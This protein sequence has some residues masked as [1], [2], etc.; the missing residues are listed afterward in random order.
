MIKTVKEYLFNDDMFEQGSS[1][2]QNSGSYSFLKG[3]FLPGFEKGWSCGLCSA[4]RDYQRSKPWK[5]FVGR[6]GNLLYWLDFKSERPGLSSAAS[7]HSWTKTRC[8]S[9]MNWKEQF[10]DMSLRKN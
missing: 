8:I 6:F 3:E 5:R 2:D 10:M 1:V 7:C 9:L 4:V